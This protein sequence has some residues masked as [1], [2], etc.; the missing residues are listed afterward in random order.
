MFS[1]Y[2]IINLKGI[3]KKLQQYL[4]LCSLN[5]IEIKIYRY[6]SKNILNISVNYALLA[7]HENSLFYVSL[8]SLFRET[9]S[10]SFNMS[11]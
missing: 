5:C 6:N 1:I 4:L 10:D 11:I 8:N 7:D 9:I 3:A 2:F